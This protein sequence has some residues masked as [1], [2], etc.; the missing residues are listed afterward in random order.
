MVA[1]CNTLRMFWKYQHPEQGLGFLNYLGM[2]TQMN[3]STKMALARKTKRERETSNW[4]YNHVERGDFVGTHVMIRGSM[5]EWCIVSA[6][7]PESTLT[8]K[9]LAPVPTYKAV[10]YEKVTHFFSKVYNKYLKIYLG[11]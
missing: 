1:T 6:S 2:K 7:N 11:A 5:D 4:V 10:P 3:Q 8:L 9:N